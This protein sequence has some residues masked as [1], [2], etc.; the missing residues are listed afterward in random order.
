MKLEIADDLLN[1]ALPYLKEVGINAEIAATMCFTKI[2]RDGG[3]AFLLPGGK[4]ITPPPSLQ[5]MKDMKVTRTV[6]TRLCRD[7]GVS[8]SEAFTLA[9]KNRGADIFWCNPPK[10]YLMQ[11]WTL[12]LNDN[13]KKELH[14]LQ[15]PANSLTD[16]DFIFRFDKPELIDLQIKYKD[17][18]YTD[19]RSG[20][21][22]GRFFVTNIPY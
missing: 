6:A 13:E 11:D 17:A 2:A 18:S 22:L 12:I 19:R 3:I 21:P 20:M 1:A 15:I 4:E 14:I 10:K 5:N 16:H 9:S 7:H 8:V